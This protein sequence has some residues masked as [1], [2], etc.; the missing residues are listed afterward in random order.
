MMSLE[1]VTSCCR[2]EASRTT[3]WT[4]LQ[5]VGTLSCGSAKL[6]EQMNAMYGNLMEFKEVVQRAVALVSN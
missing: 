5:I 3:Y 2:L 6:E 4:T 1:G